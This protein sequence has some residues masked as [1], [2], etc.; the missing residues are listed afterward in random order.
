MA[1]KVREAMK[2]TIGRFSESTILAAAVRAFF[3]LSM[4]GQTW[5]GLVCVWQS[6][7]DKSL[8]DSLSAFSFGFRRSAFGQRFCFWGLRVR[9]DQLSSVLFGISS[10]LLFPF[11]R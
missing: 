4:P 10:S 3:S 8:F 5:V 7:S 6:D 9:I 2:P 11:S 1:A